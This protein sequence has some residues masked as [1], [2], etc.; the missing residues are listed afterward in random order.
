[1]S[2]AV[3]WGAATLWAMCHSSPHVVRCATFPFADVALTAVL[4]I[5]PATDAA[6]RQTRATIAANSHGALIL[7]QHEIH[8]A[9]WV[10][11]VSAQ[12]PDREASLGI[13]LTDGF[14]FAA[15]STDDVP[16]H[17]PRHQNPHAPP[18][19]SLLLHCTPDGVAA[20]CTVPFDGEESVTA[21]SQRWPWDALLDG[22]ILYDDAPTFDLPSPPHQ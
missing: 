14:V 21:L 15:P 1:M 6:L 8:G 16:D 5:T 11:D 13:S 19:P 4:A 3:L 12:Q 7:S 9:F 17:L 20:H 2:W 22:P 10:T 18:P